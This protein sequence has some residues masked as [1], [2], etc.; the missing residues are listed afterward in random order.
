MFREAVCQETIRA[1]TSMFNFSPGSFVYFYGNIFWGVKANLKVLVKIGVWGGWGG[2]VGWAKGKRK[3]SRCQKIKVSGDTQLFLRW[4]C[5]WEGS[6]NRFAVSAKPGKK[7]KIRNIWKWDH[8]ACELYR[9]LTHV[10]FMRRL[11]DI[12]KVET[13]SLALRLTDI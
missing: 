5:R 12:W 11:T 4:S 13:R 10:F 2:W 6:V 7:G 3:K 1:T 8:T 9:H